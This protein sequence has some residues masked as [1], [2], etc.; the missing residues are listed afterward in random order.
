[1]TFFEE[2]PRVI[3]RFKGTFLMCFTLTALMIVM[4]YAVPYFWRID[5]FIAVFPLSTVVV[6]HFMLPIA[7]NPNLMLFTW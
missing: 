5:I 4:V 2:I 6:S 1:V 3:T 7:L